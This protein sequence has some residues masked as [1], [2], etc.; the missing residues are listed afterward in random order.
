MLPVGYPLGE[1]FAAFASALP[2]GVSLG[3]PPMDVAWGPGGTL[4]VPVVSGG[5][6][7]TST[8]T[9]GTPCTA[10]AVAGVLDARTA[11]AAADAV[12]SSWAAFGSPD[13]NAPV[14][15]PTG[16]IDPAS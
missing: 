4:V 1:A 15:T 13:V 8:L 5:R 3:E 2:A 11:T 6:T 16:P 10:T 14:P 12:C 7:G 9:L